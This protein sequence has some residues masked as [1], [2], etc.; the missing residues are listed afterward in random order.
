MS[1][2]R[3][4]WLPFAVAGAILVCLGLCTAPFLLSNTG[5]SAAQA[6]WQR[7]GGADY[8]LVVSQSCF[9]E[10]VGEWQLTV[11]NGRVVTVQPLANPLSQ[12]LGSAVPSTAPANPT[13][14]DAFT[15]EEM[16][17]R[18]QDIIRNSPWPPLLSQLVIAYDPTY[19]YVTRLEADA[20]GELSLLT[21]YVS[22]SHYVYTARAL[23]L[24][25]P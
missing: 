2:S 5:R 16:F 4:R 7:R 23:Q 20:N 9:C 13:A 17:D 3:R 14:F 8:T 24:A 1:D 25:R 12:Q 21:G 19:G 11:Q 6:R 10:Y 18:S 15:V 22:D